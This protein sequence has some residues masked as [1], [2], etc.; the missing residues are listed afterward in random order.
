MRWPSEIVI[1]TKPNWK[2]R[3]GYKRDILLLNSVFE[4]VWHVGRYL[5]FKVT[6]EFVW[7]LSVRQMQ[8]E[9][10]FTQVVVYWPNETFGWAINKIQTRTKQHGYKIAHVSRWVDLIF[11]SNTH[12]SR[13]NSEPHRQTITILSHSL[14]FN[15]SPLYDVFAFTTNNNYSIV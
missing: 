13:S 2:D 8:Q 11:R 6:R 1:N 14:V 10:T 4:A 3:A 15:F 7:M 12:F 5:S 9:T